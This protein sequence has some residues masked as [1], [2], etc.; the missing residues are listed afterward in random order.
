MVNWT[1]VQ[2][3]VVFAHTERSSVMYLVETSAASAQHSTI[4]QRSNSHDTCKI[5]LVI[6]LRNTAIAGRSFGKTFG[7]V[8]ATWTKCGGIKFVYSSAVRRGPS[9]H[10]VLKIE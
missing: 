7:G 1:V 3:K 5:I 2:H 6:R 4:D 9:G 10:N 8:F